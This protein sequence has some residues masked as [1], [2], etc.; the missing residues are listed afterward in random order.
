M[1]LIAS[2]RFG[3]L[4]SVLLGFALVPA[5]SASASNGDWQPLPP[6]GSDR[7]EATGTAL[8]DGRIL[9]VGG[10]A[11]QIMMGGTTSA[12][13]FD[14]ATSAWSAIA[15]AGQGHIYAHAVALSDGALLFGPAT[16]Y[17][18]EVIGERWDA[19]TDA[20]Q[21]LPDAPWWDLFHASI[22]SSTS[23]G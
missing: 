18:D 20:W 6:P 9:V 4:A 2:A 8:S 11:E 3:F 21:P 15:P 19:A 5:S 7:I 10:I 14:P 12:E 17:Y 22:A 1:R 16:S 23:S 13:V